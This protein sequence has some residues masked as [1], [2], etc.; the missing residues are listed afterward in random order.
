MQGR[1]ADGWDLRQISGQV[2]VVIGYA[3]PD[4]AD[5]NEE[6][7]DQEIIYELGVRR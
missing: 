3:K 4:T 7:P 6:N 2:Q 5:Q 1:H